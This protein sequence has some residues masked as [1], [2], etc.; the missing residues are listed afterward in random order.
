MAKSLVPSFMRKNRCL[1]ALERVWKVEGMLML[2]GLV[3]VGSSTSWNSELGAPQLI[4]W[5]SI[6]LKA[7]IKS[8]STVSARSGM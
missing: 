3:E 7:R 6:V 4:D 1:P 5:M 2:S 8:C